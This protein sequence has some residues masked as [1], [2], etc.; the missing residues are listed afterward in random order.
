MGPG[1][2]QKKKLPATE[3]H[4]SIRGIAWKCYMKREGC[5]ERQVQLLFS[6]DASP[7][8]QQTEISARVPTLGEDMDVYLLD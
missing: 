1:G 7:S 6:I 5:K 3:R 4:L 2:T 8:S